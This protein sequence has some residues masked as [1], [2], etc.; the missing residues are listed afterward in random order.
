MVSFDHINMSSFMSSDVLRGLFGVG[1]KP[2]CCN[3]F[4]KLGLVLG[5]L[6]GIVFPSVQCQQGGNFGTRVSIWG[7]YLYLHF[8]FKIL[9]MLFLDFYATLCF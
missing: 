2:S 1:H 8:H 5:T 9:P 4:Y 3:Y 7:I 6:L